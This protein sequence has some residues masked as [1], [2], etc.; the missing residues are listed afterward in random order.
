[1]KEGILSGKGQLP[2]EHILYG[3]PGSFVIAGYIG[4]NDKGLGFFNDRIIL[5][6][7]AD[8][9]EERLRGFKHTFIDKFILFICSVWFY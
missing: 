7:G 9:V 3:A 1:M 4:I 5:F 2:V 8:F 6:L